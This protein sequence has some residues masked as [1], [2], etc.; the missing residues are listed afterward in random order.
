MPQAILEAAQHTDVARTSATTFS[1]APW[2]TEGPL[3]RIGLVLGAAS[4]NDMEF[5][6]LHELSMV[7][8]CYDGVCFVKLHYI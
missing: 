1:S 3:V 8:A 2:Y 5:E 7:T 4:S 6:L